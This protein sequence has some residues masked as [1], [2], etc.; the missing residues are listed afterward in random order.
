MLLERFTTFRVYVT[1]SSFSLQDPTT[2][3]TCECD[4]P[5]RMTTSTG[6][7]TIGADQLL[8]GVASRLIFEG[9]PCDSWPC[10]NEGECVAN[11][12][13]GY[14]CRCLPQFVGRHCQ[15]RKMSSDE[16]RVVN[17]PSSSN[18]TGYISSKE[19]LMNYIRN[20]SKPEL[21]K[22]LTPVREGLLTENSVLHMNTQ[23]FSVDHVVVPITICDLLDELGPTWKKWI[24]IVPD[25][26]SF[27]PLNNGDETYRNIHH[28]EHIPEYKLLDYVHDMD[29]HQK[30]SLLNLIR[31]GILT[32]ECFIN[33]T[34]ASTPERL[35]APIPR[36]VEAMKT[37]EK[38]VLS[39]DCKK[40]LTLRIF[41]A[42]HYSSASFQNQHKADLDVRSLSAGRFTMPIWYSALFFVMTLG[43]F[44]SHIWSQVTNYTDMQ[45]SLS[46]T[47]PTIILVI[48]SLLIGLLLYLTIY[49]VGFLCCCENNF[50]GKGLVT[51]DLDYS[52]IYIHFCEL[53]Q[54]EKRIYATKAIQFILL[55][56]CYCSNEW[57]WINAICQNC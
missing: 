40:P 47:L 23:N 56:T 10:W 8:N 1:R 18:S 29:K 21:R 53:N 12:T 48:S 19:M 52:S 11:G 6:L 22:L 49:M 44:G 14:S 34:D 55:C 26:T 2:D 28:D 39:M 41:Y 13:R 30:R 32:D 25:L 20:L 37:A 5:P 54:I 35:Q 33:I 4:V 24:H 3:T 42:K 27:D 46:L 16:F 31:E 36:I 9:P 45:D 15:F 38:N 43:T 7:A 50:S 17:V 51:A 57:F